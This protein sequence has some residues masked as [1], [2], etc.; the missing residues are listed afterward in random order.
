MD[1]PCHQQ[2]LPVS[3]L[4]HRPC[5]HPNPSHRQR[6]FLDACPHPEQVAYQAGLLRVPWLEAAFV[7]GVL[8]E[9]ARAL[10]RFWR[11]S[12]SCGA[13]FAPDWSSIDC[14]KWADRQQW[15]RRSSIPERLRSVQL[16]LCS[17]S[18]LRSQLNKN[19]SMQL[20][21]LKS[22]GIPP[23]SLHSSYSSNFQ[24]SSHSNKCL[25]LMR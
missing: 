23:S 12:V 2:P 13:P 7:H 19:N 11:H 15:H 16:L 6:P 17:W 21:N 4:D 20:Q 1:I 18:F 24:E 25:Q 14:H 10:G 9:P 22:S 5:L 8:N 3:G